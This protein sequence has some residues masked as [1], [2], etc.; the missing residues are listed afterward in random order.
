M[1][2]LAGERKPFPFLQFPFTTYLSAFSPN[3][4][5]LAYCST[6]SGDQRVYVV[7]FPGPGGKWQVSPSGGCFARW[8]RDGK[9]LF[10]LSADNKIMAAEVKTDGSS[11]AIGAVKP[12]FETRVYRSSLGGYDVAADGQRFI[13]CYEPG[14]PNIAITLVENWDAELKKK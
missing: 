11:F 3:G 12:L 1:L 10:Y 4:K 5:W 7:P 14:Q 2:P 8:R 6:E 9:E 13:I